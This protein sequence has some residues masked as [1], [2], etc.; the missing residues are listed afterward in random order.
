MKKNNS[1]Y[2]AKAIDSFETKKKL[3]IFERVI[4]KKSNT[5]TIDEFNAFKISKQLV[6][7]YTTQ[8][9]QSERED[10]IQSIK[11]DTIYEEM[12]KIKEDPQG[13]FSNFQNTYLEVF[14][15]IFPREEF[16]ANKRQLFKKTERG[17]NLEIDRK[18][19]NFEYTPENCVMA[20]YWCNNAKTDEF[21]Y[22][23]FK[24][25]GQGISS[26]WKQRLNDKR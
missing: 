25:I 20:C 9:Y 26:V 1:K 19:S 10:E 13:I 24:I 23:E 4:N 14:R 5:I 17:W 11:I 7:I 3:F 22:E 6:D 21:T 12:K 18:N 8:Y 16:E 15:D 2:R